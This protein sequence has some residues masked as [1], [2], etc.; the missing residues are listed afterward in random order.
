MARFFEIRTNTKYVNH[1]VH[2]REHNPPKTTRTNTI[3]QGCSINMANE[4]SKNKKEDIWVCVGVPATEDEGASEDGV[5]VQDFQEHYDAIDD[6]V[7]SSEEVDDIEDYSFDGKDLFWMIMVGFCMANI[8]WSVVFTAQPSSTASFSP[9]RVSTTTIPVAVGGQG[10]L[11]TS[12][13]D[14]VSQKSKENYR[15]ALITGAML[16]HVHQTLATTVFQVQR[17]SSVSWE[18]TLKAVATLTAHG[19]E[20]KPSTPQPFP[21]SVQNIPSDMVAI[22]TAVVNKDK[23]HHTMGSTRLEKK[24]VKKVHDG[25]RPV[26]RG[27]PAKQDQALSNVMSGRA[28]VIIL[29][30]AP[31]KTVVEVALDRVFVKKTKAPPAGSKLLSAGTLRERYVPNQD[32]KELIAEGRPTKNRIQ[33]MNHS[34][35][36]KSPQSTRAG[37]KVQAA[38]S[39]HV[40]GRVSKD[41]PTVD[42]TAVK[43]KKVPIF[44]ADIGMVVELTKETFKA[45]VSKNKFAF[46]AYY[47]S[48]SDC[49]DDCTNVSTEWDNFSRWIKADKLTVAVGKV[50]CAVET[51]LC[52][53]HLISSYPTLRW[54]QNAMPLYGFYRNVPRTATNFMEYTMKKMAAVV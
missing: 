26:P 1:I 49:G 18:S 37:K 45:F 44:E 39:L 33:P 7:S 27:T 11:T 14:L 40:K 28:L 3:N 47:S 10:A 17:P 50:D 36:K 5:I 32:R 52:G 21:R 15:T 43:Q 34:H 25:E 29:K 22:Q 38:V 51:K 48:G 2:R 12:A 8:F 41:F 42:V 13:L 30:P 4:R 46:V 35:V 9:K 16:E 54:Y 23:I 24:R 19:T 20:H 31:S 53:K 6:S